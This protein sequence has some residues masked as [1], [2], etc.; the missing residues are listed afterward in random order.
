MGNLSPVEHLISVYNGK[1]GLHLV[2]LPQRCRK[3]ANPLEFPCL[4]R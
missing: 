4:E 3:V 2:V 1:R